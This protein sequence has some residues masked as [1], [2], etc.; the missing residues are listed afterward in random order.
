MHLTDEICAQH[1]AEMVRIPTVSH[2]DKSETD[3]TQFA[4]F[5]DYLEKTYPL[6]HKTMQREVL[7]DAALLYTWK[8]TGKSKNLPLM[9]IGHQDVV[10]AGDV[11]GWT[12]PPFDGVI[13]DGRIWGRG[14][15]DCKSV[16]VA[17]ME[18][19]EALIADGFTPDFDVYL[20]YGCN[21]EI[22]SGADNSAALMCRTLQSRGVRL[23]MVVDEGASVGPGEPEGLNGRIAYVKIAE[24]GYV[25]FKITVHGPGGHSMAPSAD[26]PVTKLAQI[27]L[28]LHAHPFAYRILDCIAEEY[29]IKAPRMQKN[30]ELCADLRAN[31]QT[32]LPQIEAVPR[33]Q[34]KFRSTMAMTM[35]SGSPQANILPREVSMTMNCRVLGGDT[36]ESLTEHI[37]KVVAGRGEV[38]VLG[39]IEASK[40]S[41]TDSAAFRCM[42]ETILAEYPD[43]IVVPTMVVGGTDAKNYYPI[44]DNV[45]RFGGYPSDGVP[46]NIHNYNENMPV[47]G[48]AQAAAFFANLIRNYAAY[49][50]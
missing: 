43:A 37:R 44:C 36:I 48:C 49:Q 23:G 50:D 33:E 34:S 31:F 40:I 20:G 19:L 2:A 9:L 12:Y 3:F 35:L 14:A 15:N 29:R 32:L 25:N 4:R 24:K 21:E 8:G 38:E 10:P 46:N 1:L 6:V 47:A 39:G 45:Y 11:A 7:G 41:R 16:I 26:C 28:D 5:H 22:G 30:G 42:K 27:I 17:H 18:A 13:A